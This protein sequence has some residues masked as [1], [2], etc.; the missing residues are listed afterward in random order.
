MKKILM[1]TIALLLST[2][3]VSCK[4]N[5]KIG[6]KKVINAS[7]EIYTFGEER[8]Y[9]VTFE[10]HGKGAEP[11]A[12]VINRVRS[13]FGILEKENGIYHV[14]VIVQTMKIIGYSPQI[15]KYKN[16]VIYKIGN[17]EKFVPIEFR[18]KQ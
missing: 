1:H 10:T 13:D 17:T 3:V 9:S 18:L 7:Y 15:S 16:G 4:S 14:D 12:V 8:G 11:I 5:T 2:I 6:L